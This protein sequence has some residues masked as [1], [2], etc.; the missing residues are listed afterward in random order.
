MGSMDTL[1]ETMV[2]ITDNNWRVGGHIGA[3]VSHEILGNSFVQV[4]TW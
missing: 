2:N 3:K 1:E 4:T